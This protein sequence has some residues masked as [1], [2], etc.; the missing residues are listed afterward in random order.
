V[1]PR[2][3]NL[4][5]DCVKGKIFL[6]TFVNEYRLPALLDGGSDITVMQKSLFEKINRNQKF[7]M[8]ESN[9]AF[10]KSFSDHTIPVIGESYITIQFHKK[11]AGL[12]LKVYVISDIENS[13]LS[14]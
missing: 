13:P 10:L 7:Y 11:Y 4:T 6:Q 9:I 8:L 12:Q 5:R 3:V 14:Y 2:D 1:E